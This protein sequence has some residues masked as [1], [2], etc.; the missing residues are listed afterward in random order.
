MT[1]LKRLLPTALVCVFCLLSSASDA[2]V[3]ATYFSDLQTSKDF[4]RLTASQKPMDRYLRLMAKLSVYAIYCDLRNEAG[5]NTYVSKL[6]KRCSGIDQSADRAFGQT[7]AYNRFERAR[8][9]ES[10]IFSRDSQNL[11]NANFSEFSKLVQMNATQI[12]ERANQVSLRRQRS[13]F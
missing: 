10:L 6:R 3:R 12:R 4:A 1:F 11:C 8:N 13:L 9:D 2:S 5:Y 7:A